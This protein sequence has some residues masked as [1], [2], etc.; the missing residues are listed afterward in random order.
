MKT[1][2][3]HIRQTYM[4]FIQLPTAD[5]RLTMHTETWTC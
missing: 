4:G 5:H 3:D 2:I 1:V